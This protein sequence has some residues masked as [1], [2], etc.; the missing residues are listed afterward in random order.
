M[1]FR[2]LLSLGI[3]VVF[4]FADLLSAQKMP[5]QDVVELQAVGE[6]LCV[7]NA[8]QNN[9]V[10]Q[11]DKAIKIWGWAAPGEKVTVSLGGKS[12][13]AT[14]DAK[15]AWEVSLPALPA[16]SAPQVVT[17]EGNGKTLT[18]KNILI[19]DVWLL[20]GQSNMAFE[21]AKVDEG[22]LEIASANFP[23]IRLLTVPQGKG[24]D[25][26]RSFERLHEWSGWFNRH[27]KKGDWDVCTPETVKDFSAIGYIFGR[28]I[29]MASQVPIGLIDASRGGTT[30]ETWTPEAV[31]TEIQ[32]TETQ[33]KL[34]EWKEKIAAYDAKAE[35]AKRI[36]NFERKKKKAAEEGKPLPPESER[37]SD[38]KP[39]PVADHNRPGICYAGMITPLEGLS[40]K[41]AVFHQ[42]FNNCFDG[43]AGARMYH[44]V[45][46]EMITSWRTAFNDAKMPFCIISLCTAGEPQ[47]EENFLKSMSNAGPLVREAQYQTFREFQEGGDKAIGFA[48]S[49]DFRKTWY[50]PQIKVPAGERA[51][52]W[53]LV[54]QYDSLTGGGS[55]HFWLPPTI[56]KMETIDGVLRLSMSSEIRMKD[57]S[58]GK[59][60]GFAIAGKDRRFYP[61]E[62]NYGV[63][64]V[65][66]RKRPR[67]VKNVLVL[68][69]SHVS[70]PVHYRY[71]WARNPMANLVNSRQIPIATQRSD[72]WVMEET[73]ITF[74]VPEGMD[75]RSKSRHLSGR[76]RKELEL[77]DTERRIKEA[78]A[79]IAELKET[80][81]AD[82]EAWEKSKAKE[83]ARALDNK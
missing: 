79:T 32:K 13:E 19:G 12:A 46:G 20:G 38:L 53:A 26:V 42:G 44:Q 29:H 63:D 1:K 72:D 3:F 23:E 9:M 80:F 36:E 27:F 15:R 78:E 52:K 16:N 28:R 60:V 30:V 59:M 70:E 56:K 39:G 49:F 48:S 47:T 67:Q 18:L 61:A 31:L 34:K 69:S 4:A 54:T 65:D 5:R 64:G 11:R 76:I 73:P 37:P 10:L 41:G 66:N 25:S 24:F 83:A 8:F 58:D 7:S 77:A 74:P 62:I 81:L 43:S 21:L 45:F 57:D 55:E 75:E 2:S 40:V 71:A 50:H 33:A 35:L 6:G 51:A 82:K 68:S 22:M 14:A 17:I